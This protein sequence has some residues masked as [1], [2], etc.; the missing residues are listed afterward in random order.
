M[1]GIQ[2]INLPITNSTN[3][4]DYR[5]YYTQE[6]KQIVESK[7]AKEINKFEYQY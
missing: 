4:D 6:T 5:T 1:K 7:F 2:H 3:H